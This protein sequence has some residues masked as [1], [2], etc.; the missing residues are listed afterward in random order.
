MLERKKYPLTPEQKKIKNKRQK[1]FTSLDSRS[2]EFEA[3]DKYVKAHNTSRMKFLLDM[4]KYMR[5]NKIKFRDIVGGN[6]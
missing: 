4:F 2:D 3:Y 1:I 5:E 6:K